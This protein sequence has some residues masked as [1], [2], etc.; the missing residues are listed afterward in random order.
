MMIFKNI[1]QF[2]LGTLDF[3][4]KKIIYMNFKPN[5]VLNSIIKC[6]QNFCF[7]FNLNHCVFDGRLN[8]AAIAA[9]N[10]KCN[11]LKK[12]MNFL[13]FTLFLSYLPVSLKT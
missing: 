2:L 5:D 8:P 12:L 4:D 6:C 7:N 3:N 13:V 9:G 11:K 1:F 10:A